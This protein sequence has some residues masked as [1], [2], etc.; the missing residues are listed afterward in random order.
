MHTRDDIVQLAPRR[1]IEIPPGLSH[2]FFNPGT[3]DT[4]F[5]VISSPNTR[6]DRRSIDAVDDS[7]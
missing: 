7:P 1:G 2:R 4:R 6:G 3:E 5:L